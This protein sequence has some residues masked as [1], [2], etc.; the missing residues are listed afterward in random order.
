MAKPSTL[1]LINLL[2]RIGSVPVAEPGIR[3]MSAAVTPGRASI[4]NVAANDPVNGTRCHA[5]PAS[6]AGRSVL[7]TAIVPSRFLKPVF[8]TRNVPT[9]QLKVAALAGSMLAGSM[10]ALDHGPPVQ[11]YRHLILMVIESS[12]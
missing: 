11:C 3:A 8:S 1:T 9:L 5:K 7:T 12:E 2:C 10:H 4:S 6:N